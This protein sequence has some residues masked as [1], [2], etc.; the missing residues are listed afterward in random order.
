MHHINKEKLTSSKILLSLVAGFISILFA[1][2]LTWYMSMVQMTYVSKVIDESQVVANK[3]DI[4]AS[5]MEV[6]RSRTRLTMRMI[7]TD[8]PFDRDEI[9]LELNAKASEFA[10]MREQLFAL[11]LS[12]NEKQTFVEMSEYIKP[13]LERQRYA[14]DLALSEKNTDR[15]KASQILL[16]EV[17][18]KQGII[19][20][21]FMQMLREQKQQLETTGKIALDQIDS[22]R[23]FNYLIFAAVLFISVMIITLVIRHTISTADALKS[24]K[25]KAQDTIRSLG[26]AVITTDGKGIIEY[27]NN[28]AETL[29]G[30]RSSDLTGQTLKEG[31]TAYDKQKDLWVWQAAE[32]LISGQD[33][34]PL[35][36]HVT[37]FSFDKIEYE[38]TVAISPIVDIHGTTS[39]VIVSFHDVTQSQQLMKKIQHQAAHDALTG[40]LNRREFEKRVSQALMLFNED[41]SHAMCLI[42]LDSFKAVNDSCGH[43]AGDKMLKQLAEYLKPRLRRSDFFARMGGDEFAIFFSNI[44]IAEA[45]RIANSLLN[46]IRE[47]HFIWDN[48]TFRIGASIGMIEIPQ[49]FTDYEY[50]YK[51]ADTACYLAKNGGRN[52]IKSVSIDDTTLTQKA[53]ESNWI[54]QINNALENNSFLLFGQPIES[55][56]LRASGRKHSEVLLRMASDKGAIISPMAFIPVA[57]RYG[58]MDKIDMWVFNRVCQHIINTPL[59]HTVLAVNLSGQTLSSQQNMQ[60]LQKIAENLD[61][62]PGRLCLE[63]TE[64]VAIANIELARQFMESMQELGCYIALDDFGSGLSSFSYLKDLPLDYIKIDG[65]F[66]KTIIEDKSSLMMIDAIHNVG[67]KLGLLTIAEY[68]ESEEILRK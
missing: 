13:A 16:T 6:A 3:M 32:K 17:Y 67:K 52:Q 10:V 15:N 5:L 38:V 19:V 8:D 11:G 60:R 54:E 14:A 9:S 35:S 28:T 23:D 50:L 22:N 61:L 40:L 66:V 62:P 45:N 30:K 12:E 41:T 18:P 33:L 48:K 63:I 25:D 27:V 21:M 43:A 68:I 42:D 56:S 46:A 51:A 26:D 49:N 4:V 47:F 39:G 59:D 57:E 53:I 31:F 44:D 2:L 7:H 20:D 58:M 34:A 24:E 36:R 37:L 64:T 55:L 1:M 65:A 29:I